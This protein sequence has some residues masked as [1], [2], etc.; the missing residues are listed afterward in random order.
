MTHCAHG[1]FTSQ[2]L[3]MGIGWPRMAPVASDQLEIKGQGLH[4]IGC[5][6]SIY[7]GL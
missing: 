4:I 5:D 3:L 7:F 6:K 1:G 2:L